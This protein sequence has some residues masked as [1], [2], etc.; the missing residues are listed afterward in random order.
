MAIAAVAFVVPQR[1]SFFFGS[2]AASGLPP[3]VQGLRKTVRTHV[4]ANR[5][6]ARLCGGAWD[7]AALFDGTCV[8]GVDRSEDRSKWEHHT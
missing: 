5:R 3:A 6:E 8:E 4:Q 7:G 2:G 1:A